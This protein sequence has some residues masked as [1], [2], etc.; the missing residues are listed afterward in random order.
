MKT[1]ATP[2]EIIE[3][4]RV[5][6]DMSNK[7]I[8]ALEH[9]TLANEKVAEALTA[10]HLKAIDDSEKSETEKRQIFELHFAK[11]HKAAEA[12]RTGI[13]PS[14]G[15]AFV[16]DAARKPYQDTIRSIS[17]KEIDYVPISIFDPTKLDPATPAGATA[18]G[19]RSQAFLK[20]L[21][22]PQVD[23][24]TKGEKLIT[25]ERQAVKDARNRPLNAAFAAGNW[26]GT[27]DSAV[28]LMRQMRPEALEQLDEAKITYSH[29]I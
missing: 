9:N 8:T 7:E 17:D 27:P 22:Q 16:N 2:T 21:T 4:Q 10:Q 11:V 3:M 1:G 25:S 23:N 14:T 5:V 28:E 20:T 13:D 24:L 12:L 15:A 6:K 29:L 26:S 18:E 19:G